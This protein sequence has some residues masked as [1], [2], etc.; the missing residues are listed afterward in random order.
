MFGGNVCICLKYGIVLSHASDYYPQGNGQA[1]SSNKNL[2][3]IVKKIVGDNKRSWD[4]KIKYALWVDRITKKASTGKSPFELV[5]GLEAQLPVHLTFP[6]Y[7]LLQEFDIE[8]TTLQNRINQLVELDEIRRKAYDQ[9]F[10][11]QEK[12]NKTFDKSA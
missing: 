6:V 5:Y 11:S 12:T 2:M 3:T 8:E 7:Q 10:K 4:S 1:E 9:N